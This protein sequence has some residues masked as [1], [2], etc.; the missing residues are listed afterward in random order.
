MS[1]D[2]KV[3]FGA[4]SNGKMAR[5]QQ[6]GAG[7]CYSRTVGPVFVSW[8]NGLIGVRA[9]GIKASA[10]RSAL[11][12]FILGGNICRLLL[13]ERLSCGVTISND[14]WRWQELICAQSQKAVINDSGPRIPAPPSAPLGQG[15]KSREKQASDQERERGMQLPL[16]SPGWWSPRQQG[17]S[18]N[19]TGSE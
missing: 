11:T 14:V 9:P 18:F 12:S 17:S 16:A 1:R 8:W 15:L 6:Q 5:G 3:H 10:A 19:Q 7:S 4:E 2:H 13:N